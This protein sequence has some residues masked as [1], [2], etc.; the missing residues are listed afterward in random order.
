MTNLTAN[1]GWRQLI[2][3]HHLDGAH[4]NIPQFVKKYEHYLTLNHVKELYVYD[5]V[6]ANAELRKGIFE[7]GPTFYESP[8]VS[9]IVL[10]DD[11]TFLDI[12]GMT[13]FDMDWCVAKKEY[14]VNIKKL[15]LD[16]INEIE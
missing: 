13:S 3:G 2:T 5:V 16:N 12:I 4:T 10:F 1:L 11:D 9:F 15:F 6:L 7:N 14:L 8:M